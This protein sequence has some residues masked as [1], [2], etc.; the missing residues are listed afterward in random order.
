ME[1]ARANPLL[2][3]MPIS[4]LRMAMRSFG[5]RIP[6]E[7]ARLIGVG[8]TTVRSWLAGTRPVRPHIAMLIRLLLEERRPE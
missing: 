7:M 5:F 4:E 8:P 3:F 2:T 1:G 6:D